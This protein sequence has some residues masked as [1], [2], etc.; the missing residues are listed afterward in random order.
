MRDEVEHAVRL[1]L[2]AQRDSEP[3]WMVPGGNADDRPEPMSLTLL[4]I[5]VL[6]RDGD[7][8]ELLPRPEW[9]ERAACR[10]KSH[11]FF[12][13]PGSDTSEAL[14]LCS[15]CP[16]RWQCRGHAATVGEEYGIWGG[17]PARATSRDDAA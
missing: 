6:M 4:A 3:R 7:L 5:D 16:V 13:E 12:P 17:R 1:L 15:G 14:A 2:T 10:G 8:P 9:H 11:L